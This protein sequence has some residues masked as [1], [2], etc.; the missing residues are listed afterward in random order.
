MTIEVHFY[1]FLRYK[2]IV[3]PKVNS[4]IIPCIKILS[5]TPVNYSINNLLLLPL[6]VSLISG[7]SPSKYSSK[8]H[9]WRIYELFK[10]KSEYHKHTRIHR[11]E[12]QTMDIIPT[13]T[14]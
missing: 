10:L 1:L 7:Y 13:K 2:N 5:K 3:N 8:Q 14:S 6:Q 12:Q 4:R 11:T 9:P